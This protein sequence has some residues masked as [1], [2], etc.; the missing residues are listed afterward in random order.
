MGESARELTIP[1]PP[2]APSDEAEMQRMAGI[3]ARYGNEIL[4]RRRGS[5]NA[6]PT[7]VSL[8]RAGVL[9]LG[10]SSRPYL[11]YCLEGA[12]SEVHMQNRA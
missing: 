7:P 12:F 8:V 5:R 1:P 4:G 3:A 10:P 6:S 9:R 2:E 11:Y